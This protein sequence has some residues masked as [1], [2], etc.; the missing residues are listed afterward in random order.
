MTNN[1]DHEFREELITFGARA[2]AR[3]RAMDKSHEAPT[4]RV[5]RRR[6]VNKFAVLTLVR[7]S[8]MART[9]LDAARRRTVSTRSG[10]RL[11]RVQ[12]DPLLTLSRLHR[13]GVPMRGA[14]LEASR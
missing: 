14:V 2:R 5:A 3:S 12:S 9:C 13:L 8:P 10:R 11:W 7:A 1:N 6:K 4:R